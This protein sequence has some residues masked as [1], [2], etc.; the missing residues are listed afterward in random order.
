MGFVNILPP[1]AGNDS[2]FPPSTHGWFSRERKCKP[3][4]ND[5][6]G[7]C[8]STC[9]EASSVEWSQQSGF[10]PDL[11]AGTG[12]Y[13]VLPEVVACCTDAVII[14]GLRATYHCLAVTCQFP[15]AC[16]LCLLAGK[17]R[18]VLLHR[19]AFLVLASSRLNFISRLFIHSSLSFLL[20][21]R[22]QCITERC[23][24][25]GQYS[26]AAATTRGDALLETLLTAREHVSDQGN[27]PFGRASLWFT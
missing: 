8:E 20:F 5:R 16:L 6:I 2:T 25:V 21:C 23:G 4:M 7:K 1:P 11:L 10:W 13:V 9:T 12:L 19:E 14:S 17:C 26:C 15:P 18:S 3:S 24:S 27:S 22:V